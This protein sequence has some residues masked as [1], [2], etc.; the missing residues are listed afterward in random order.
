M[1][2][3]GISFGWVSMDTLD[4][5]NMLVH[6]TYMRWRMELIDFDLI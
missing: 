2:W 4:V 6:T 5:L 3:N 1:G